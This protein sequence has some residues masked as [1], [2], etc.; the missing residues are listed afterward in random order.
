MWSGNIRY[1]PERTTSC[2]MGTEGFRLSRDQESV[3]DDLSLRSVIFSV[4]FFDGA[5][6]CHIETD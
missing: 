1:L 6:V 3:V 5:D 2:G 4:Q